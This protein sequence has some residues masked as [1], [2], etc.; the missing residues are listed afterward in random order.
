MY[1]YKLQH[2]F[3]LDIGL[4]L[5]SRKSYETTWVVGQILKLV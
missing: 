1:L 5:L 2:F 4:Y 3:K